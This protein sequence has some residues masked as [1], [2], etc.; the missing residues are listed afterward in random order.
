[1]L[2]SAEHFLTLLH[3]QLDV[4]LLH[5][6]TPVLPGMLCS[7]DFNTGG[8]GASWIVPVF[9]SKSFYVLTHFRSRSVHCSK[10]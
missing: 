3:C 7:L 6:P 2:S 4:F 5:H 8:S 9:F 1:M 10:R